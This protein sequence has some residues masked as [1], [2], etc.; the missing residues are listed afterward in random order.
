[1]IMKDKKLAITTEPKNF[2]FGLPKDAGINLEHETYSN[3]KHN[4][5]LADHTIGNKVKQTS[6]QDKVGKDS[7]EHR[8]Q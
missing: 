7:H 1:M 3:I 6:F 8:K 2:N 5:P 4:K